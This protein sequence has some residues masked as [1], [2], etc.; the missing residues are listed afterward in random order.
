[1]LNLSMNEQ[2]AI[3]GG[4]IRVRVYYKNRLI[5]VR[6]F[7]NNLNAAVNYANSYNRRPNYRAVIDR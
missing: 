3:M 6:N 4:V 1:M 7:G 2:K 5:Q